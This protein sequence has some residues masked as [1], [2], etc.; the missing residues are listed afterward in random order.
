MKSKALLRK[1]LALPLAFCMG[2]AAQ[3][4][5]TIP[6]DITAN[7]ESDGPDVQPFYNAQFSGGSFDEY[8][9]AEF[10]IS[11]ADFGGS[12]VTALNSATLRLVVTDPFFSAN[13]P[14]SVFF[15]TDSRGDLTNTG[16]YDTLAFDSSK[17]FGIDPAAFD[18]APVAVGNATFD[19]G[20]TPEGETLDISVDLSAIGTDLLNAINAGDSVHF[21]IGVESTSDTVATFS[22]V[23]GDFDD[24]TLLIDADTSGPVPEPPAYPTGFSATADAR[25]IEVTWADASDTAGYLVA[26]SDTNSFTPPTDGTPPADDLDLTDGSGAIVAN[27]GVEAAQFLGLAEDTQYFFTIFPFNN[28]GADTDYKTNATP[29]TASATTGSVPRGDILITQYY[30]GSSNNKYLELTNVTENAVDLSGFTLTAWSDAATEDWKTSGNTT[31]RT[32]DLSGVTLPAGGTAL[33]ANPNAASPIPAGDAD[34]ADGEATFFNGNDSV[35]LYASSTQDPTNIVDALP[36][37]DSGNEGSGT[38][39]VRLTTD[40]GYD[41][42]AGTNVLDFPAVWQE[43][44]NTTTTSAT[45]GDDAFLGSSDLG[46][47][48]P[49]IFFTESSIVT[50]E[51][52][53]SVN[54]TVEI[55]NP[56]ASAV[57]ADIVFATGDSAAELADI[58]NYTTQTVNFGSGAASGDQ[59][60]V[61]VSIA[62]DTDQETTEDAV[63]RLQNLATSGDAVLGVP[64]SATVS[65]QDNDTPMPDILI[66]EIADPGDAGDG[67]FVELYN[68]TGTP[69]DLDAGNWTLA[70]FANGN[71]SAANIPLTGTI[72]AGGTYIVAG[73][74]SGFAAYGVAAEDQSSGSISGN[75]NDVYALYFAGDSSTGILAD[76]YGVIGVDGSGEPW[77]YTDSRAVRLETIS[78]GSENWDAAEWTI[79]PATVA[80]ATP[81]THPESLVTPPSGVSATP[82]NANEISVEF[83]PAGGNDV[84]IVFNQ[85]G[86]FTTPSGTPP[87]TGQSFAGGT[88]LF[89]G[90]TS[91]FTH[92]GLNGDTEYFYALYSVSGGDYSNP[93]RV[94]ATTPVAGLINS[95]DFTNP[96][97]FNA[98]L[99]GDDSWDFGFSDAF[100]DGGLTVASPP[101]T[102]NH[103]LVSPPLDFSG[104]TGVNLVF[105]YAG[106]FDVTGEETLELVYATDYTDTGDPVADTNSATWN[107]VSFSFS[108][109]T[110]E[111]RDVA[112]PDDLASS[113]EIAL[114]AN[115]D[116]QSGVRLAFRYNNVDGTLANSEQ[117]VIDNIVVQASSAPADP[118]GDYLSA[119][120]LTTGDLAV[121]TNGNGFPVLLEYLAGFGDGQGPDVI[122]VGMVP[123]GVSQLTLTGDRSGI[124]DGVTVELLATDDLNNPFTSVPF[125]R[126]ET[127]NPDGS[128]THTYAED[129]PPDDA[130][131]FLKLRINRN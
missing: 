18:F 67:K 126:S 59:Q 115:L 90:Q 16:D 13:G 130:Q 14:F 51:G 36:F 20:A 107:S 117:W 95:E 61:T 122:A 2:F 119:R 128:V 12:T 52:T 46:S 19:T 32:T 77:E 97:W 27:Q 54:L 50:S 4:Q 99:Q 100:I 120:G 113:G 108:N 25:N 75:G 8:G 131:R 101:L 111:Q 123:G 81:R 63:F 15:T 40:P 35:V 33:V 10:T 41:L 26:I 84:V 73:S 92:S 21:L 116:G 121:D 102:D 39:F 93:V 44:S 104:E 42:A 65:I 1:R 29:P 85:T 60:T 96:A 37:T 49:E 114:P 23:G 129:N 74:S 88:L 58:G 112:V 71:T 98:T 124:P 106:A 72:P 87:A 78:E 28:S 70:R 103:Y 91:P 118:V 9:I 64:D 105:D 69:V 94:D 66:S 82:I 30:E 11:K 45:R 55:R 3:A 31:G 68:P 125:T 109:I 110:D 83:T 7:I 57:S 56:D 6:A 86:N 79:L 53:G 80:D 89:Q 22:G 43:T 62:D 24:P 76:I 17:P 5:T 38:G 127:S 34:V 47:P 48:P